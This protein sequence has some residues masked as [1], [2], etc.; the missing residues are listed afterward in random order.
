MSHLIPQ[1]LKSKPVPFDHPDWSF[2][3]KYDGFRTAGIAKK[4]EARRIVD[5]ILRT[6]LTK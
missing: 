4:Y 5:L 1:P 6:S 2:E 3:L